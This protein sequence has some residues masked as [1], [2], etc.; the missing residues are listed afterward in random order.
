MDMD[1]AESVHGGLTM[2]EYIDREAVIVML[3]QNTNETS[4]D[5]AAG[6]SVA[7]D[8]IENFPA[9]DVWPVVRGKWILH[10]E[11]YDMESWECSACAEEYCMIEG[12]PMDNGYHF[13][14]NCGAMMTERSEL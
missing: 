3:C 11:V 6:I 8:A 9:A 13:C 10:D 12:T 4:H 2:A 7:V 5:Y 1:A 14:P